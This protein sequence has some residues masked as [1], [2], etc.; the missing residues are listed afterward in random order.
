MFDFLSLATLRMCIILISYTVI[1][2]LI[3]LSVFWVIHIILCSHYSRTFSLRSKSDT[4]ATLLH[5]FSWVSTQFGQTI[6]VIQCDN[7]REFDNSS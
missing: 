7:G 1:Y 3:L 4:F 6:M 2:G 5:F